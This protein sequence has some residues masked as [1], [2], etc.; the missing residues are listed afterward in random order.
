MKKQY[1]RMVDTRRLYKL[2]QNLYED[3]RYLHI[4]KQRSYN[5]II[6]MARDI[7]RN[8]RI[9]SE[10]PTIRFGKG[11]S[12][13]KWRYSWCDGETI[14]LATDQQDIITLIHELVHGMGYD[15]HDN[16]FVKKEVRLL[17]KYT[18][19]GRE[20]IKEAFEAYDCH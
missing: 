15:D 12:H 3:K 16:E 18:N 1:R 8:E 19:V 5:Y 7:W 10:M 4:T 14:E 13:G 20:L 11:I 2:E 6:K 17:K 9:K